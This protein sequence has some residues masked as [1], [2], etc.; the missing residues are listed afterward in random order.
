MSIRLPADWWIL[1]VAGVVMAAFAT[2]LRL[3]GLLLFLTLGMMISDDG[4]RLVSLADPRAAQIGGTAALLLILYEGGLTTKPRDLRQAALPGLLLATV[5]VVVT[6]AV[7][8]A[9]VYLLL[10]VEPMTAFLV[11]AVVAS[12]DAAAV[13]AVLRRAS[14]CFA[15]LRRASPCFAVPRCPA[16]WPP[17]WRSSPARTTRSRSC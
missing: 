15:V 12:T 11:G 10:D 8:G 2:R 13:F 16:G 17:C 1:L 14:P 9:G 6:A 7:T 5:A 4:L 3:P